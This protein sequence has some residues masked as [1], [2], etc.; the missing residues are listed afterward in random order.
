MDRAKDKPIFVGGVYPSES[1]KDFIIL[2]QRVNREQ[3]STYLNNPH[4]VQLAKEKGGYLDFDVVKTQKG[5]LA[6]KHNEFVPEKQ[7]TTADHNPD[8]N[9]NDNPFVN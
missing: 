9:L 2:K 5:N 1:D 3:L 6:I 8:R 4:V 7:V